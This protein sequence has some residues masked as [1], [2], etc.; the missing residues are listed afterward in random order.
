MPLL[1]GL[2][3]EVR[4]DEGGLPAVAMPGMRRD[5]HQGNRQHGQAAA[6]VPVVAAIGQDAGR[7]EREREDLQIER[8][9]GCCAE[10]QFMLQVTW[11]LALGAGASKRAGMSPRSL[12][13][14]RVRR[15]QLSSVGYNTPK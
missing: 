1:R 11:S 2:D 13:L 6:A 4:Q 10:W 15:P 5:V 12:A 9:Y 14:L 3:E 7:A 8:V